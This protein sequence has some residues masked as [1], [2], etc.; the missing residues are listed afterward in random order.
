[1]NYMNQGSPTPN[2]YNHCNHLMHHHV[3]AT[4][5]DGSK[6]DGIIVD[7]DVTNVTILVGEDLIEEDE[8]HRQYGD[9]GDDNDYNG[10]P[11]RRRYRRYRPYT[12]PLATLAALSLLPYVGGGYPYY[13]P[14]YPPYPY[15]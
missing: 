14:Y 1:M 15:Y 12:F 2:L 13:P 5:K 11:R 9:Y 7:V 10:R 8:H 6:F 4:K 3:M